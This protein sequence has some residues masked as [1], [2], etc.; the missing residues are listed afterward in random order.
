MSERSYISAKQNGGGLRRKPAKCPTCGEVF[1]PRS[2][3]GSRQKYCSVACYAE[4]IR[5]P[6]HHNWTG[7]HVTDRGYRKC[8]VG[9]GRYRFEHRV[10]MEEQLGRP[11]KRSESVHH[12]N[13]D[14]LDNR[15]ENL[16]LRVTSHG[17]GV[18]LG[19]ADCGSHNIV[20]VPLKGG[21]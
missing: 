6:A 15:P 10:V 16:Q 13:G 14:K 19:C 20:A 17:S 7:G 18:A 3:A 9:N 12:I 1:P 2:R 21:K 8:Y 4:A 5:G 11:L